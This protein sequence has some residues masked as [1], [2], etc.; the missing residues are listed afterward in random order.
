MP[1]RNDAAPGLQLTWLDGEVVAWQPGRGVY[2]GNLQAAVSSTFGRPPSTPAGSMRVVRM[3]LPDGEQ[4]VM[5][6]RL[7]VASLAALGQL[8]VLGSDAG[9]SVGWLGAAHSGAIRLV[10]AGRV[11]P[12]LTA[13]E[14]GRGG[15]P[16]RPLRA[17]LAG[18]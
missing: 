16:W 6:Q 7:T 11:L 1:M 8:D 15:A 13:T 18:Q 5:C 17:D 12:Q 10:P 2:G 14:T 4:Q 9:A 3:A